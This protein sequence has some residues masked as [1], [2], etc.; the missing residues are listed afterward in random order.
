[1]VREE[2]GGSSGLYAVQ[3]AINVFRLDR[4]VLCGVPIEAGAGHIRGVE[5][6]DDA[7]LYRQGWRR[8]RPYIANRVR[9]MSGWTRELLGYPDR[10]W[11]S[12]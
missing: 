12:L 8:A 5:H 6:W 10:D 9:S 4:I 7:P 2:W 1:M 11:L 3:I